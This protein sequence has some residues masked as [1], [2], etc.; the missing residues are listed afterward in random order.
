M[1]LNLYCCVKLSRAFFIYLKKNCIFRDINGMEE[2]YAGSRGVRDTRKHPIA[3]VSFVCMRASLGSDDAA[4]GQVVHGD[5]EVDD[6]RG[7]DEGDFFHCGA[8]GLGDLGVSRSLPF[9]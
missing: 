6:A 7:E 4:G 3:R 2:F 8:S 9:L 1:K 5:R